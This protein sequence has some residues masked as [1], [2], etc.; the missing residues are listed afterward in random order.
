MKYLNNIFFLLGIV[1]LMSSCEKIEGC[2]DEN[3]LNYD[4]TAEVNK[5][6]IYCDSAPIEELNTF[7]DYLI[8]NRP[9]AEF[10]Q[11]SVLQIR[12]EHQ[13][14]DYEFQQCGQSG[15]TFNVT[16]TNLTD[17][18]MLGFRIQFEVPL[19]QGF[20]SYFFQV[21]GTGP[22]IDLEPG[23]TKDITA[24]FFQQNPMSCAEMV[25]TGFSFS[26]IFNGIYIE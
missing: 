3:A 26:T 15:C 9:G 24:T 8:E 13:R 21:N 7:N 17:F 6:C 1:V 10:F 16:A 18:S 19:D 12:I 20:G 4:I 22:F 23:E 5:G 11:D 14:R 2:T 25:D